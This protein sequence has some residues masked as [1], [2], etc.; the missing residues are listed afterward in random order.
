M[1]VG[2][3]IAHVVLVRQGLKEL[4][5]FSRLASSAIDISC[6]DIIALLKI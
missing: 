6:Q 1:P 3:L 2:D 5:A 4:I